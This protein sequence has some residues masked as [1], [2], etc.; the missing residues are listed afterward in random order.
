MPGSA[1]AMDV[2][3]E[4]GAG[5]LSHILLPVVFPAQSVPAGKLSFAP[6]TLSAYWECMGECKGVVLG[7][8][9]SVL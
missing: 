8:V 6:T 1:I 2:R 5:I 4:T 3:D 9:I 7:W